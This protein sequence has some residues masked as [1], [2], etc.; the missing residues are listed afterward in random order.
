MR[1]WTV[2]LPINLIGVL[3]V[4]SVQSFALGFCYEA[5]LLLSGGPA[6]MYSS[7]PSYVFWL[8]PA[9]LSYPLMVAILL[10]ALA[11]GWPLGNDLKVWFSR[12]TK[13]LR[14]GMEAAEFGKGG[15][16]AFASIVEE[17]GYRHQPGELMLG[18][19]L[20]EL[21]WRIGWRDDRGFLTIAGSRTGK[22]RCSII[23]NLITWPGSAL[24]IDPKGTNAAV[25]AARRG[26]GGGRVTEFLGQEV[27]VVDPFWIVKGVATSRFNP[28]M[29]IS[30]ASGEFMEEDGLLAD[31]L[32]VQERDTEASH[33]DET[34]KI[35]LGG[36]IAYLVQ[37]ETSP[38]LPDIRRAL[39][40]TEEEFTE[41]LVAMQAVDGMPRTAAAL[42]LNAGPNERGS[43]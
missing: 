36:L 26:K 20:Q 31:A 32:V 21:W 1:S 14:R 29:A 37:K 11:V 41:L 27:H 10:I 25:T 6:A 30:P 3:L 13:P 42:L 18:R 19:S 4:F 34:V 16:S 40:A 2:G 7:P 23:P 17:W 5:V 8:L 33:W 15:S 38:T 39:T 43:F 22:G 35:L 28:L 9:W 24:V 12:A